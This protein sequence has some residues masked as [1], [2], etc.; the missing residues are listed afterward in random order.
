MSE[1]VKP[2]NVIVEDIMSEVVAVIKADMPISQAVHLMLRQRVSGYPVV[3][4]DRKV[5]GIVTITDFF[6]FMEK[7]V[8]ESK[9]K[10]FDDKGVSLH[11]KINEHKNVSVAELMSTKVVTLT[12][13]TTLADVVHASVTWQIHT[14]PVIEND[15]LVGIVGRHDILNATFVYA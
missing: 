10:S 8:N 7:L 5:I 12:P 13:Q 14:F 4:D 9:K 1:K 2:V 15:K 6:I 3:D 11:E